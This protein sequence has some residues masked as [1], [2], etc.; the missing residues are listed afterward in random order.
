MLI[1]DHSTGPCSYNL[2]DVAEGKYRAVT[3]N[4]E[5]LMKDSG[6][7]E[8]LWKNEYFASHVIS[9]IWDESHCISTWGD[10][11]LAYGEAARLQYMIPKHIRF[12]LASATLPPVVLS[13]VMRILDI[14]EGSAIVIQRSNDRPNIHIV[15][16]KIRYTL[17]SFQDLAFIILD[18]WKPGDDPPPKFLIFFDD[19]NVAIS[20]A[21]FLQS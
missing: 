1:R 6:P 2:Q 17:S 14:E 8:K 13:D 12:H 11:R 10:F 18:D 15:V 20:A 7:F 19:I 9:L 5:V 4:P 16:R 3:V 21:Q